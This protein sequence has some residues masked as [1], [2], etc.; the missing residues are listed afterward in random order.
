MAGGADGAWTNADLN[1]VRSVQDELSSHFTSYN[2]ASDDDV[3]GECLS[4]LLECVHEYLRVPICHVET[5]CLNLR[6]STQNLAHVV[7][8]F[9]ERTS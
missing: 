6:N 7:K 5:D 1:D 8:I 9:R 3:V 2:I 4:V